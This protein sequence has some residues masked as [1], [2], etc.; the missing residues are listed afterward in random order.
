MLAGGSK[1]KMEIVRART[2]FEEYCGLESSLKYILAAN[3]QYGVDRRSYSFLMRLINRDCG[4]DVTVSVQAD[5]YLEALRQSKRRVKV[6]S[7]FPD[8]L[9]LGWDT[10][11]LLENIG[12]FVKYEGGERLDLFIDPEAESSLD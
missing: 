2:F 9:I 1:F 7:F 10:Q 6:W 12:R 3:P 5:I 11:I 8:L 4:V